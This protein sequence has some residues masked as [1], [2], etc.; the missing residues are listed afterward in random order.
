[1]RSS[2][3]YSDW[4][5]QHTIRDSPFHARWI[6]DGEMEPHQEVEC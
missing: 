5:E 1:M 6:S 2:Y 3:L 4:R